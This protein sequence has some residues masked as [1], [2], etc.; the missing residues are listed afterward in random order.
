MS[1]SQPF[2]AAT[3]YDSIGILPDGMNSGIAPLLLEKSQAAYLAN[4][5]VR[6][7]FATCRPPFTKNLTINYPD[8]ETQERIEQGLFQG[9][10]PEAYRPDSGPSSQIAQIGGYLYQFII[11]G[12]VVTVKDITV[13]G[14]PN[15]ATATQAWLWQAEN[16]VIV[17]DGL[18]L[19]IFFDG[20]TSRRSYGPT[21]V[22]GATV[23]GEIIPPFGDSFTVAVTGYTGPIDVA[24]IIDG[25]YYQVAPAGGTYFVN[26]TQLFDTAATIPIG[27]QVII[28][29]SIAGV[30]EVTTFPAGAFGIGTPVQV[31]LTAPYTGPIGAGI[32]LFGKIFTVTSTLPGDQFVVTATQAGVYST[33]T[34][35]TQIQYSASSEPNVVVGTEQAGAVPPGNGNTVQLQLNTA[36]SGVPGQIV[37]I[38]TAGQYEIT[39]V[40]PAPPAPGTLTLININ[41]PNNGVLT[42]TA[43][44]II[45]VPELPAGRMGAY[46]HAQNWLSLVD[47]VSFIFSDISGAPSGTPAYQFRDAV[48]KTT[49]ITFGAG[50]FRIPSAG[51]VITSMFFVANL[52]ESMGQGPLMVG[53]ERY[54]FSCVAPVDASNLTAIV[55]KGTPILTY[56]LIGR[57][58][59]AQNSTI[60]VNSD[61]QFR[62]TVGIGSL[63]IA[64]QQFTSSLSG[65]TPISEE[66]VRVTNLDDK[67][68]LPYSSAINFDNRV[69]FT[70]TPQA[71]S[72]GV[73]HSSLIVMNLD[74]LSSLRGK[75]PACYDGQWTGLNVLQLTRGMFNGTPRAFAFTFNVTQS[76]IELYELLPSVTQFVNAAGQRTSANWYD[77]ANTP[78]TWAVETAAL[79]NED[80]KPKDVLVQLMG[81]EFA[82]DELVGTVRFQVFYKPDQYGAAGAMSC[83]VPWHA[84]TICA[85]AGSK[86]LYFPRLGLPEPSVVGCNDQ[87]GT[88]LR[89]GYTFQVRFVISGSCRLLRARFSAVT[90]PI[91]KFAVPLCDTYETVTV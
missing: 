65:N 48:L 13:P 77:N 81:G 41:A 20:N 53:T 25:D 52:D 60:N 17:Q 43:A 55:L 18:S 26:A 38:G 28:K 50:N 31:Q 12:D 88:P 49:G 6:D 36:F 85:S 56:A 11:N 3:I 70:A 27:T 74:G 22:Y 10:L 8:A 1:D 45:S 33:L 2:R 82:V 19:P 78:I 47:G 44:D 71:S 90:Q 67:Q 79:F 80:V 21:Q 32:I 39:S 69:L 57:G 73:F 86:P 76:K 29:P 54:I 62:S 40:T 23:G 58:P 30:V 84:F 24:V 14:D 72:Q 15:P 87:L 7:G 5:T 75:E 59:L 4:A 89:L 34:A 83:W 51:D 61:I 9:A 91:P 64:R 63:V 68:L 35:G 42:I 37:Y 66:M 16:F 46:G